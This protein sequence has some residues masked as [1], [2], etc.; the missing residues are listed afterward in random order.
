MLIVADKA[1]KRDKARLFHVGKKFRPKLDKRV[2]GVI[3][4]ESTI[5]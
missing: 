3:K 5:T 4:N 2:S 1:T